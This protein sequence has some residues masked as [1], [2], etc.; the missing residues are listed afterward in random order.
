MLLQLVGPEASNVVA[1][2][3]GPFSTLRFIPVLLALIGL[4]PLAACGV[5]SSPVP[6]QTV[7]PQAISDLSASADPAGINLTWSRPMHYVSGH[8]LRDLGS[9]VLLRSQGNQSFQPLVELPI[10]DQERFSPQRTFSY[11]DG[12]TQVGNS[13]RYEIVSRTTDGYIS[14]PSNEVKF[15]RVRPHLTVKP[16]NFVLPTPAP[17]PTNLP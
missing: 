10:T 12:E 13:Y 15:T 3:L 6:P 4:T 17:L 5:K 9:F 11:L 1:R 14:A 7:Y 2:M 8:S 16:Q